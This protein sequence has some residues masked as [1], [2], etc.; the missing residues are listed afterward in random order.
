MK[1]IEAM[2]Q[3]LGGE[4]DFIKHGAS[5]YMLHSDSIINKRSKK[6]LDTKN[7]LEYGWEAFSEPKWYDDLENGQIL[8]W[9]NNEDM[10]LIDN[11][12][13]DEKFVN[14]LGEEFGSIH[15]EEP[16]V[17]P[18]KMKEVVKYIY[19]SK[20]RK[21]TKKHDSVEESEVIEDS[22][23][24]ECQSETSESTASQKAVTFDGVPA[25]VSENKDYFVDLGLPEEYW[26]DFW[27]LHN[28]DSVS[29]VDAIEK[30]DEYCKTLISAFIN[31]REKS[32]K[33][34]IP[35]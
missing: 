14:T 25:L 15:N 3:L 9:I 35:F 5:V 23:N 22:G 21:H 30:G 24:E 1:K 4:C 2:N 31:E 33:D 26:T 11:I 27:M 19:G 34:E 8:C 13:E 20:E 28:F 32:D 7:M 18:V 10:V 12:S 16:V 29:I 6:P 17:H